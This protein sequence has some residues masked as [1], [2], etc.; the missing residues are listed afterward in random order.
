MLHFPSPSDASASIYNVDLN[1]TDPV[2]LARRLSQANGSQRACLLIDCQSLRCL[3]T[4]G[5]SFLASQLLATRAAGADIVLYN[6]GPV[7]R[8]AF[9]LLGLHKLFTLWDAPKPSAD[10][11]A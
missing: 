3:R 11:L 2:A 7:L 10:A 8:R 1:A 5:V 4:R 9:Q 6:V